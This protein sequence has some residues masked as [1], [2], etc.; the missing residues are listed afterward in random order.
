MER[1]AAH[2]AM[3]VKVSSGAKVAMEAATIE[4]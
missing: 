2:V 1:D 3:R 4:R